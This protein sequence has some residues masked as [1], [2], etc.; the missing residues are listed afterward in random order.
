MDLKY[1]IAHLQRIDEHNR[2][3]LKV[4]IPVFRPGAIGGTPRVEVTSVTAG[5]DW[6]AGIIFLQ[7]A[8]QLTALSAEDVAAIRESVIKGISWHAYKE[9][10]KQREV[11]KAVEDQRDEL[12]AALEGLV[13][14]DSDVWNCVS[15]EEAKAIE[16]AHAAIAKAKGGAV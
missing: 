13:N 11:Q 3:E 6:D 15:E 16:V 2:R 14:A 10:L 1:L 9:R 12:L 4:V 8:E 5:F 7:P